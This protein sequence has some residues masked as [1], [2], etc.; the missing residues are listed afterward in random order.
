MGKFLSARSFATLALV[1]ASAGGCGHESSGS[2]PDDETADVDETIPSDEDPG[3][4]SY[5]DSAPSRYCEC[6]FGVVAMSPAAESEV[7]VPKG[8]IE[9]ELSESIDPTSVGPTTFILR[10]RESLRTVP[11]TVDIVG[12]Q[13]T[14]TP[15]RPLSRR[16]RYWIEVDGL[17]SAESECTADYAARFFT[18]P[19]FETLYLRYVDGVENV[20]HVFTWNGAKELTVD[21]FVPSTDSQFLTSDDVQ[22][23][24][25]VYHYDS[26]W[27]LHDVLTWDNPGSDAIWGTPDDGSMYRAS[28]TYLAAGLDAYFFEFHG[29]DGI[30]GTSDDT[31]MPVNDYIYDAT[32]HYVAY[33]NSTICIQTSDLGGET[34]D[35]TSV[36]PGADG[37]WLTGDDLLGSP[38]TR[39][40][41]NADG[42][43]TVE[44]HLLA[45]DGTPTIS[46]GSLTSYSD[47][48]NEDAVTRTTRAFV[49]PGPD[50][51]WRTADDQAESKT[52]LT[53]DTDGL[54][55]L[56]VVYLAGPDGLLDT[57]DDL[58]STELHY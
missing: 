43:S 47:S 37:V 3:A 17:A 41:T 53:L 23:L 24:R 35:V 22:V 8:V 29:P 30:P 12:S 34:H 25:Q 7:A 10:E 31:T 5:P 48:L 32:D 4:P 42:S 18:A 9:L 6:E 39:R 52:T 56:Q 44:S 11:I 27:D 49:G 50:G 14:L 21:H 20:A 33:C 28:Y 55:V 19:N 57:A 58:L 51:V 45:P 16:A 13:V 38:W 54:R 40:V 1:L 36:D 2:S 26:G 46:A 15:S